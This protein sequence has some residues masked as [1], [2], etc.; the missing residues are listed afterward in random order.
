[1]KKYLFTTSWFVA[2]FLYV[3]MFFLTILIWFNPFY[4]FEGFPFHI[5]FYVF[6]IHILN[7]MDAA[8]LLGNALINVTIFNFIFVH[9]R[10]FV[11]AHM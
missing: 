5:L 10:S 4:S 3:A 2:L 8:L 7:S 11:V 9:L 1:M 6:H